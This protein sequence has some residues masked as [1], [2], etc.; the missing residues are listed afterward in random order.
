MAIATQQNVRD[1]GNLT[2]SIIDGQIT[3]HLTRAS[4]D[5]KL[6]LGESVYQGIVQRN[7]ATA[8]GDYTSDFSAGVDGW[9]QN[10]GD[11]NLAVS[12]NV[13]AFGRTDVLK[14]LANAAD[15]QFRLKNAGVT[16]LGGKAY[17]LRF[18]YYV[19]EDSGLDYFGMEVSSTKRGQDPRGEYI[20]VPIIEQAWQIGQVIQYLGSGA[21]YLTGYQSAGGEYED[22]TIDTIAN[23]KAVYLA[24]M[25]SE[26]LDDYAILT[27]AEARWALAYAI[28]ALAIHSS[29]DGLT[30]QGGALEGSY[31]LLG[32]DEIRK[33]VAD[34]MKSAKSLIADFVPTAGGAVLVGDGVMATAI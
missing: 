31:Q 30:I 33:L 25:V 2:S 4:H 19:E 9:A 13:D 5:L 7:D 16:P 23:G 6:Y 10:A 20:G 26:A 15:L 32:I 12:G 24:N 21:L 27:I 28:E 22:E 29:G 18:D 14:V 1:E 34:T 3:P 11:A 17:K 8:A